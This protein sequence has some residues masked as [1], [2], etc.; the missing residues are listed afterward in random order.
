MTSSINFAS[1]T[2]SKEL[3]LQNPDKHIAKIKPV[4]ND[5][6]LSISKSDT[7]LKQT[8]SDLESSSIAITLEK[9]QEQIIENIMNLK[10][11]LIQARNKILDNPLKYFLP[12]YKRKLAKIDIELDKLD[13]LLYQLEKENF[14]EENELNKIVLFAQAK[15]KKYS[16]YLPTESKNTTEP[17]FINP[18]ELDTPTRAPQF[19]TS[20]STQQEIS[21]IE[22]KENEKR[23]S[24]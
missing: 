13:L 9:N 12:Y 22:A 15:L 21:P 7:L 18:T 20:T 14:I 11:P 10:K 1:T 8:K 24:L 6:S 4:L 23:Q 2:L 16:H 3:I 17:P 19:D 5:F